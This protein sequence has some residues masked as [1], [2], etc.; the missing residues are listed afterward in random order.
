MGRMVTAGGE[1]M[2]KRGGGKPM[3]ITEVSYNAA[4]K[5]AHPSTHQ[6]M[7]SFYIH[8]RKRARARA[9]SCT[10]ARASVSCLSL[11][12]LSDPCLSIIPLYAC[13]QLEG[14]GVRVQMI[15]GGRWQ[16]LL[17]MFLP[18]SFPDSTSL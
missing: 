17:L 9:R 12:H 16:L 8:T 11:I 15:G 14:G 6:S 7:H 5:K 13:F 2:E 4:R 1:G 3:L 10:H 18:S